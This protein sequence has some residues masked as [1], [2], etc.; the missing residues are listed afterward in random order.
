P[1]PRHP[2]PLPSSPTRR[3]SD[4]GT[5]PL[6]RYSF[7]SG[8][9]LHAACFQAML[10]VAVPAAAWYVLPFTLSVAASRVVLGLH[11]PS[12]VAAGA[13]IGATMGWISVLMFGGGFAS[14]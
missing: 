8:H 9:T 1:T 10:F 14:V 6:D 3:S 13:V 4:L 12:D 7:P 5:P 2:P 11:Y